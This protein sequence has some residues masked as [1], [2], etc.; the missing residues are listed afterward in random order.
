MAW[1]YRRL[2]VQGD[3]AVDSARGPNSFS[4]RATRQDRGKEE[5]LPHEAVVLRYLN[6]LGKE[7]WEVAA[8]SELGHVW[9]YLLK[10]QKLG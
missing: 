1:E 8:G 2:V 6:D 5:H 7:N 4:L 3:T 9:W 10:R